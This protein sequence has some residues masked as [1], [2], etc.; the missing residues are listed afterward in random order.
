MAT[1]TDTKSTPKRPPRRRQGQALT[2]T[3]KVAEKAGRAKDGQ[4]RWGYVIRKGNEVVTETGHPF[5]SE[6]AARKAG[7]AKLSEPR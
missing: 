6:E 1:N 2:L 4:P 3:T 5:K 7:E